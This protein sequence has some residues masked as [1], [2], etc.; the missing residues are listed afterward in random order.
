MPDR[1]VHLRQ[2]IDQKSWKIY[3]SVI[4]FAIEKNYFVFFDYR[5]NDLLK[6]GFELFP[7]I[8][9]WTTNKRKIKKI[10]FFYILDPDKS[11]SVQI[12]QQ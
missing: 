6:K 3:E 4:Y 8:N 12:Q 2:G 1:L 11:L 7:D 9:G 10:S 5:V